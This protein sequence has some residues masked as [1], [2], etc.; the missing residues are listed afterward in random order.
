VADKSWPITI[1]NG[2][3]ITFGSNLVFTSSINYFI[4]G[5]NSIIIDGSG[6]TV[7]I[8][9]V[10]DYPGLVQNGT[11]EVNG[12]SNT[13]IQNVSVITSGSSTLAGGQGW[14]GQQ[15]YSNNASGNIIQNCYSTGN[16]SNS[17]CGGIV[18]QYAGQLSGGNI[19]IS[20]CS[21]SGAISGTSAGG[22]FGQSAGYSYGTA[23]STNCYT[24]GAISGERSGGIFGEYAG[25]R[26]GTASSINC[27]TTG[28]ISGEACGG[29]FGLYTGRDYGTAD[30]SNCHTTGDI[31]GNSAGGIFGPNS[32]SSYGTATATN[33]YTTGVISGSSGGGIFGGSAGQ[34]NGTATATNCYTT[35][36][37]SG[38]ICGGIFGPNVAQGNG[39]AR[40]NNCFAI[41]NISGT[42]AGGIFGY[43]PEVG[44]FANNCFVVSTHQTKDTSNNY[45]PGIFASS[46]GRLDQSNCIVDSYWNATD[47]S[48]TL[49]YGLPPSTWITQR[50]PLGRP[51]FYKL[52]SNPDSIPRNIAYFNSTTTLDNSIPDGSF[53]WP[54]TITGGSQSTP[55]VLTFGANRI[56][57]DTNHY[58][59]IGSDYITIDGLGYTVDISGVSDYPGLVQNGTSGTNGYSNTTIQNVSVRSIGSS[60]LAGGQGWIGQQYY[61]NNASGNIIQYCYSTGDIG[62]GCGGIVGTIVA[63]GGNILILYCSTTGAITGQSAGGIFGGSAGNNY[64]TA[65][66]RDCYTTGV[67]SGI[68]AGGI[69]GKYAGRYNGSASSINCHTTGAISGNTSGGIFGQFA[70]RI[71]GIATVSNCYTT[72]A[73]SGSSGGGIF[74]GSAG[75]NYGTATATNC[76]TTGAISGS[77][78]GG[79][80]GEDCRGSI[81]TKCFSTGNITGENAGGIFGLT[82]YNYTTGRPM[83]A[84]NCYSTGDINGT[85]AG[86]IYGLCKL[87][88]TYCA[89]NCYSR[90][91]ISGTYSGGIFGKHGDNPTIIAVNCYSSG[92]ITGTEAGGIFG[93]L[94]NYTEIIDP[95][96]CYVANGNWNSTN[97]SHIFNVWNSNFTP[98][99][100]IAFNPLPLTMNVITENNIVFDQNAID[101]TYSWPVALETSAETPTT[102]VF[103]GPIQLSSSSTQYFAV[104][105]QTVSLVSG[106]G[107]SITNTDTATNS[108]F[109]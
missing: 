1:L 5:S 86:G 57:S 96:N 105:G 45:V 2:A 17:N 31:T 91:S 61:S 76:Y 106:T 12:Y 40:A 21:T 60:T 28:I 25:Y 30:A 108:L 20:D 46:P 70:G 72:G 42:S 84:I 29:I 52:T 78:G 35:G 51:A 50:D 55:T 66:A 19:L 44:A 75:N 101:N 68:S 10:S 59:V 7:D 15:Y 32:A 74:G 11:N 107:A 65:T 80:F 88:G 87:G 64:G 90:G 14:I 49:N 95:I 26:Y 73:I 81:A 99:T 93:Q 48:N 37:I 89:T 36:A 6:Y 103:N 97:A 39:I 47:A 83:S 24:T 71:N 3:T 16:I 23:T 98:Y 18:G 79:I 38:Q 85:A 69:F 22:I 8:S 43:Y 41:G 102:I 104:N 100:L 94:Y 67:I 54:L 92:A 77:S 9:D 62:T 109:R 63:Y 27:H 53:S 33:S 82:N 56:F 34:T 58:F 4:M 13:T